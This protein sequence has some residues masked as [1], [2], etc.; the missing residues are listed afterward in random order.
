MNGLRTQA[1]EL[2]SLGYSYN[3]IR[4]KLGV[5]VST[6][7]YWFKDK[8]FVPN[9]EVINRIKFGPIENGKRRH[10]ERV[11]EINQLKELGMKE[12]G[13]LSKR[14]LWMLG[15]GLY[16]GEGAKT[17]EMLRI[18]NSD[19]AVIKVSIRWL[20]EICNLT[21]DNLSLRLHLYPDNN[22]DTSMKYW[23]NITNLPASNFRKT[24]IDR[25]VNKIKSRRGKLPYG[26]VHISVI[27]R[28][29]PSKGVKL[30]RRINGWM[31]GG[32]KQID[33]K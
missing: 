22:L 28:G 20:K 5:S 4:E 26:T 19:P 3:M 31:S 27:S 23:Q 11:N 6:Q 25:R 12:V 16:I 32:L 2:R 13:R 7:S 8:P 30:Y 1:E 10:N 15:L 18:S 24:H 14:D 9:K 29:D 17:T 33:S 21:D